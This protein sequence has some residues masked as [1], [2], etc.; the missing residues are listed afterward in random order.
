MA[1]RILEEA[2]LI[3]EE[4]VADLALRSPGIV[5]G[6]K[7]SL[8]YRKLAWHTQGGEGTGQ[9][10]APGSFVTN[11]SS[12]PYGAHFCQ[13]SV[14]TRTGRINIDKYFA[15]QDCGTPINPEYALGQIYGGVLKSIGHTLYEE[16]IFDDQGR[17]LTTDLRSYGVP[18]IGDLPDQFHCE[19]V[20]V[21]DEFGPYGAKSVAEISVNGAAPVIA[22]A[23]YDAAGI[24]LRS[25]PFSPEKVLRALGSL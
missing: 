13:V 20:D 4:P 19:L 9:I 1:G 17:C 23:V 12:I 2:A 11:E 16:M 14:N 22:N 25:W 5:L 18:T 21:E 6:K 3:L 10:I 7:G 8:T 24:R 15:L